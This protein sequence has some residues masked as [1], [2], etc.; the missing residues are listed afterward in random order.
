MS[1]K[2]YGTGICPFCNKEFVKTH[3]RQKVCKDDHYAPCPDCG[4]PVKIIDKSYAV[5]LKDGPKRCRECANAMISK[6]A[7]SRTDEEREKILEK[8]KRTNI[9]K[10]GTEFAIQN[11][12]IKQKQTD[13]FMEKYGVAT[14]LENAEILEQMRKRN[15][16]KYGVE[17]TQQLPEIVEKTK[18]TIL[19]RYGVENISQ[20]NSTREKVRQTCLERYGVDNPMKCLEIVE[21]LSQSVQEHYGVLWP[22]Q[23]DEVK[24]KSKQSYIEHYGVNHPLKS[25]QVQS[26]VKQTLQDRYGQTTPLNVPEFREKYEKHMMERYGVH[27]PMESDEFKER[28]KQAMIKNHGVEHFR[29]TLTSLRNQIVDPSKV[30]LYKEFRENPEEFIRSKFPKYKPNVYEVCEC[31]GCTDTPVYDTLIKYN[32][33]HLVKRRISKMEQ[34]VKEFIESICPNVALIQND[35]QVISPLEIDLYLPEYQLS[36]ECNPTITHNSSFP[37]PWGNTKG[38]RYHQDKSLMCLDKGI[39][40]FH[41]FGYEWTNKQ[42][43]IKSMLCNILTQ[44]SRKIYA[45][46]CYVCQISYEECREFLNNNHKQGDTMSSIRLGL[47][48]KST[49][50]LVSVMTFG[51]IRTTSGKSNSYE[52]VEL[53][54]FCNKRDTSVVGGASKLFKHYTYNNDVTHVLSFSDVAHTSGKLYEILGFKKIRIS[55]PGYVWVHL[56]TDEYLTRVNCQ[57]SNLVNLFDDVTAETITNHTEKEIMESHGYVRVYDSGV[58]RWE[59]SRA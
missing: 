3:P 16:E 30:E 56:D 48:V 6:R 15:L 47:R 55:E 31:I 24:K 39:Q 5:F 53:S 57:K 25:K 1:E 43:V 28:A 51:K 17:Y 54:R 18:Q 12:E 42:D 32:C 10:F 13:T 4:K 19:E 29:Q 33:Q 45:R 44:N 26:K 23:S 49:D 38:Y 22:M 40:L 7:K 14:P 27:W 59:W 41:I 36:I 50:E 21:K 58:I 2:T 20:L 35:R 52:G 37:D 46:N 11:A 34:E 9:E 8:R